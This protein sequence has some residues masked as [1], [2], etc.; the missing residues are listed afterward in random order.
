VRLARPEEYTAVGELT[1][2]VY[3]DGG[4]AGADYEPELRDAA[5]RAAAGRLLVAVDATTDA[6]LGTVSVFTAS[7]GQEWAEGAGPHDVVV[8]MLAV[9]PEARGRG[10]GTLLTQACVE[11]AR[12]LG[13]TRVLL[14][15]QPT[16]TAAHRIYERLGFHRTPER[17]WEPS[18]GFL[19][20]T[21]ALEL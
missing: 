8:R 5:G 12:A 15:T 14:S 17:D 18:P 4:Y 2:R 1:A 19:L 21:Y 10:V 20:L 11:Q 7:A 3:R 6:L 13:C 16:M 9:L